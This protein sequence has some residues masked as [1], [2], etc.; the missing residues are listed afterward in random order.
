MVFLR[1][2][3]LFKA[4]QNLKVQ[5]LELSTFFGRLNRGLKVGKSV[6]SKWVLFKINY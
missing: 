5:K 6:F 4:D 2:L 3:T 1:L